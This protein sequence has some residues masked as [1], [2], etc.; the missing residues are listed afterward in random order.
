MKK[1]LADLIYNVNLISLE[2]VDL[3]RRIQLKLKQH[4]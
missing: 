4:S 1:Q 3:F 2:T